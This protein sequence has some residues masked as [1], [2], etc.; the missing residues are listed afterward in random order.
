MHQDGVRGGRGRRRGSGDDGA[1]IVEMTM[2]G[3]L[4]V[5]LLMGIVIFGFLMSFRQN[6]TQAAAEAT[7][8]GAVASADPI[9]AG[10]AAADQALESFI[11]NG[12]SAAGMTCSIVVP[13][14]GCPS[15]PARQCVEVTLTYDYA[16]HPLLPDIPLVSS[17]FPSKIETKSIAEINQ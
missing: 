3:V 9:G 5:F 12:C 4:L 1:A 11:T 7:R 10:Q 14:T 6:M 16:G 8:A 2:V 15:Q 17:F 13:S